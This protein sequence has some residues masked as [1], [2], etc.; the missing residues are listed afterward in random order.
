M[1]LFSLLMNAS[2]CITASC[3]ARSGPGV[4]ARDTKALIPIV[5]FQLSIFNCLCLCGY[6]NNYLITKIT[7]EIN[8]LKIEKIQK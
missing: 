5:N 4:W 1:Q 7:T 3:P 2:L 8:C 6:L